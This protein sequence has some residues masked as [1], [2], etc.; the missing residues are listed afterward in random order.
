MMRVTPSRVLKTV[1]VDV[2]T[3]AIGIRRAP[4][5]VVVPAA[6]VAGPLEHQPAFSAA[7]GEAATQSSR[8]AE[9]LGYEAGYK[10]GYA[11]GQRE[12]LTDAE[13][14]VEE[15]TRCAVETAEV[16]A[17]TARDAERQRIDDALAEH[18]AM[19]RRVLE[20][21]QQHVEAALGQIEE[22]A[23]AIAYEAVCRLV[24]EAAPG[25][26]AVR[27]A[28]RGAFGELRGKPALRVRLHPQDLATLQ[29]G[30]DAQAV[31][32][33][34]PKVS[35]TADDNVAIGGCMVD[36]AAGTLDARFEVQ[37]RALGQSWRDAITKARAS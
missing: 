21:V 31:L 27:A 28:I 1:T 14:R 10:A 12:G 3:R 17:K 19:T 32:Q 25:V 13:Q 9:T 4:P 2:E 16:E 37:L 35:W 30:P 7:D 18:A 8:A 23:V 24:A 15:A 5:A 34:F 11:Q 29:A 22:Q 6:S 36:T 20:H 26:D 33:G